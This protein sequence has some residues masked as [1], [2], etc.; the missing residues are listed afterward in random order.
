MEMRELRDKLLESIREQQEAA[1]ALSDAMA[2]DPEVGGQEFKSSAAIVALLRGS[3]IQVEYPFAGFETAF[4][5]RICPE[6][7]RR[8]ALLAEY[9]ALRGLGHAC[10]HCASGSASALAAL[11]FQALRREYDFGVDIIGTPDEEFGGLKAFMADQG[12]FDQYDF[13]AMVHMGP[14]TTAEVSF[15]ALDG[16]TFQWYGKPAHA[17][18]EPWKGVNALNAARLFLDATDMMRQHVIPEARMHG[19]VKYGGAASNIVPELAEVEFL[20]RAPKRRDLDQ[21]TAWVKDCA[22]AAAAATRTEL[23]ISP[24]GPPYHELYVSRLEKQAIED[25]FR[26]LGLDFAAET[27]MTGSSDMGNVDYRCPALHPIMGIGRPYTCHTK[28]FAE[29]MPTEE[30]HQAIVN[31]ASLLAALAAKLYGEPETLRAIQA[32]HRAYRGY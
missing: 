18:S 2:R 4:I 31:A 19:F 15:I 5:G 30:T 20:T 25:C 14:F 23:E 24:A 21:I 28:E 10:G 7:K 6:R 8:M 9:D 12:V 11:A 3:G 29:A 22:Q 13:A 32:D 16:M 26:G 27:G 17:A 1:F